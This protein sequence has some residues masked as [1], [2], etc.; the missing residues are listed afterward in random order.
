[1][2]LEIQEKQLMDKEVA[3]MVAMAQAL[4]VRTHE[5]SSNA[6]NVLKEIKHRRNR[7]VAFFAESKDLAHK[8]WK[9]IV[10]S[11]KLLD[12]PLA[13]AESTIKNKVIAYNNE[14]EYKRQE[15]ARLAEAKRQEAER[16]E[17]ERIEEQARKARE[18]GKTEKADALEEKAQNVVVQPTFVT[19]APAP[20]T[21]GMSIRKVWKA[22]VVD[23]LAL[24]KAIA[25][26]KLPVNMVVPSTVGVS[27]YAKMNK[28]AGVQYGIEIKEVSEMAVRS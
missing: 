13:S 4:V 21:E 15:E 3:P 6:Q 26:G 9:K 18:A 28:V 12:A 7:I 8:S 19:Q 11:E 16:K 20:K 24:C 1:M 5:D 14:V 17:R 10:D 23:L 2:S 25:E 27:S 22:E